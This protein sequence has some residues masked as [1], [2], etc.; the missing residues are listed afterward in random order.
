MRL[1]RLDQ[2]LERRRPRRRR[3]AA[4]RWVLPKRAEDSS[5]R[6]SPWTRKRPRSPSLLARARRR[7][8]RRP[9]GRRS[10]AACPRRALASVVSGPGKNLGCKTVVRCAALRP[11][12]HPRPRLTDCFTGATRVKQIDQTRFNYRS[13]Y[14]FNPRALKSTSAALKLEL[15]TTTA[16]STVFFVSRAHPS[17][18]SALVAHRTSNENSSSSEILDV[19]GR[20]VRTSFVLARWR[21]SP[22]RG[23]AALQLAKV[24]LKTAKQRRK[25]NL[26]RTLAS[27]HPRLA[28]PSL[29]S[30][31]P[32]AHEP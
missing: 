16:A 25:S 29:P 13:I 11:T 28:I 15:T 3:R 30:P 8:A 14:L 17:H 10:R 27:S 4:A 12:A 2:R 21:T 9:T 20:I 32:P 7:S 18:A 24:R 19:S 22:P 5:R 31:K 26:A 1:W 6:P 23:R